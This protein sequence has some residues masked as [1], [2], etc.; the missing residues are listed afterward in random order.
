MMLTYTIDEDVSLC[1]FTTDD[2]Q[3]LHDV[4]MASK[5]Y[6]K[7]WLGWLDYTTKVEHTAQYIQGTHQAL[8][9]QGGYP[10]TFAIIYKG[11]IAGTI[12]FNTLSKAQ[13]IGV[14]GYWLGETFQQKGIMS[15]AFHAM[16]AYGFTGLNLN[17][18]EVRVAVGNVKSR[19]LPEKFGFIREGQIRDAEWLYDHYVDHIV[20][21]MLKNEWIEGEYHNGYITK[22]QS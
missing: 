14:I 1:L 19:A 20:Y 18:I 2:V 7:E 13:K 6:L 22:H 12:G 17:R 15:K 9:E 3:A 11:E 4:T 16:I 10:Q 21:S 5:P 8:L